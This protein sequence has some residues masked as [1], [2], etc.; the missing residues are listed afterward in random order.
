MSTVHKSV[1]YK[2]VLEALAVRKDE[3]Y[4]DATVNGGGHTRGILEFG[5]KV[6]GVDV[7][8]DAIRRV[9][10]R[11]SLVVQQRDDRLN[12]ISD[13]LIL[14]QGNFAD[15]T[16]IARESGVWKASGILFDL[17]VS[18]DQL[19]SARRGFSFRNKG[20]LDMRMDP[21]LGVSAADLVN[22]LNEGELYELFTRYGE[23]PYSRRI[24]RAIVE[25]RLKKKIE[26]TLE[27]A[28]IVEWAVGKRGR[29]HPATRV[30]QA[31]RIAVNDEL[32]NLKKGLEEAVGLL[33]KDGRLVVISFH[34]LED[35]SV[36]K[37]FREKQDLRIL[38]K[39][40]IT[41]DGVEVLENPRARSAKMR[42]AQRQ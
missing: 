36:K 12:A 4:I 16:N 29:I 14:V 11:E 38:T 20:P 27:L 23:E 5:G 22:G 10:N 15:L 1:L 39:K 32:N 19:D 28:T 8:P 37:F 17:G 3:T 13:K 9:A 41:P 24:S 35:R 21:T 25:S 31:L 33:K 34:S 42:V 40:P 26:T 6:L 30:F 2:E 18:S 7:D